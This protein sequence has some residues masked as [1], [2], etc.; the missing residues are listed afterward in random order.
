MW[1]ILT[2]AKIC[3]RRRQ[4]EIALDSL[5]TIVQLHPLSLCRIVRNCWTPFLVDLGAFSFKGFVAMELIMSVV[6]L[7]FPVIQL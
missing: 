1:C 5:R 6:C 2:C 3:M 4:L 7:M